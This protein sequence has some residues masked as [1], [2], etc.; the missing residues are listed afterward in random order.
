MEEPDRIALL[1]AEVAY[2]MLSLH[3]LMAVLGRRNLLDRETWGAFV[4]ASELPPNL[5][6]TP[7]AGHAPPAPV[8]IHPRAWDMARE[9]YASALRAMGKNAGLND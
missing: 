3:T 2:M 4:D 9:K 6:T 5:H 7:L 1:E 8:G